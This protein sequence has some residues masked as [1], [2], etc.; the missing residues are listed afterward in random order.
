[1]VDIRYSAQGLHRHY[2]VSVTTAYAIYNDGRVYFS[3]PGSYSNSRKRGPAIIHP[4]GEIIYR[5]INGQH[6]R[7]NGPARIYPDGEKQYIV[8]DKCIDAREFFL[9]YGAL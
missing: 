5:N 8:H 2:A 9:M 3:I 7:I 4:D 1:M 6:Y